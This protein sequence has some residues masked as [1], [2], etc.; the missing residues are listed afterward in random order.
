MSKISKSVLG[1]LSISFF[2]LVGILYC[3]QTAMASIKIMYSVPAGTL[4][5]D[6]TANKVSQKEIFWAN[7]RSAKN[8]IPTLTCE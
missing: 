1:F 2:S 3:L 6:D 7:M 5:F 8:L 4:F